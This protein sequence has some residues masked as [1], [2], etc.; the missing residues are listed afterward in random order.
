MATQEEL[1]H[2]KQQ[3]EQERLMRENETL[4]SERLARQ[5]E[6][7]NNRRLARENEALRS[8]Y[9][10]QQSANNT[11]GFFIA[12]LVI[13]LGLLGFGLFYF[14]GRSDGTVE[15]APQT[16]Q[17]DTNIELPEVNVP[18]VNIDL[19]DPN[20]SDSAPEG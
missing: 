10:A 19:P 18:D 5:N 9:R 3:F 1:N 6:A 11:S 8:N 20:N 12:L 16:E 13:L 15:Q 7:V 14:L 4:R 2:Q 17:P